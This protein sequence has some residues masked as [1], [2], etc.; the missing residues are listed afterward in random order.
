M[1]VFSNSLATVTGPT[2]PGVGVIKEA[3][4]DTPLKDTSRFYFA[5]YKTNARVNDYCPFF[6]HISFGYQP[7]NSRPRL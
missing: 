6:D 5:V 2:P 4:L 1:A 3:T 7:C